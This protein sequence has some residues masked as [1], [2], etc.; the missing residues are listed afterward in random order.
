MKQKVLKIVSIV[1]CLCFVFGTVSVCAETTKPIQITTDNFVEKKSEDT[2]KGELRSKYELGTSELKDAEL[3]KEEIPELVTQEQIK[4]KGHVNRLYDLEDENSVVFQNKDGSET[5]YTFADPVQYKDSK[6]ELKDK[7]RT[8]KEDKS[9]KYAYE[10]TTNDV[11]SYF[12]EEMSTEEGIVV[13]DAQAKITM[14]P[15]YS[16]EKNNELEGY[17]RNSSKKEANKSSAKKISKKKNDN[18]CNGI[19][20]EGMFG[21]G[22]KVRY[23][24]TYTGIKEDIII[25]SP[26]CNNRYSFE[27]DTEDLVAVKEDGYINFLNPLTGEKEAEISPVYI[28]DSAEIP[29]SS[30]E[31]YYEL[32]EKSDGKYIVTL[33]ADEEF[34]NAESTVYPVYLDPSL[35]LSFNV[36]VIKDAIFYKG[37]NTFNET[38]AEG[39]IGRRADSHGRGRMLIS[40][41]KLDTNNATYKAITDESKIKKAELKL[42]MYGQTNASSIRPVLYS[43]DWVNMLENDCSNGMY[44]EWD[45]YT[46]LSDM[47]ATPVGNTSSAKQY[48]FNVTAAVKKWKSQSFYNPK[49]GLMLKVIN[50]YETNTNYRKQVYTANRNSL[51]PSFSITY[52]RSLTLDK[53]NVILNKGNTTTLTATLQPET[54]K[55]DLIFTSSNPSVVSVGGRGDTISGE[56]VKSNV[57]LTG[58]G[59]G[60][61]TIT[62]SSTKNPSWSK[63]CSV[64]VHYNE[65]LFNNLNQLHSLARQ[66]DQTNSIELTLQFIRRQRYFGSNWD[67]VAGNINLDFV[68]FVQQNNSYIYNYFTTNNLYLYDSQYKDIDFIH[69]CA[70]MNGILYGG[71]TYWQAILVGSAHV[72]N[73]AGWA[74]DLQTLVVDVYQNTNDS[75]NYNTF[76][77]EFYRIMGK[78][79]YSFPMSDLLADVDAYNFANNYVAGYW[80]N[81]LMGTA[82]NYYYSDT[83]IP[84]SNYVS[85]SNLRFSQFIGADSKED[86]AAITS[87]YTSQYFTVLELDVKE[88]PIYASE[89]EKRNIVLNLKSNQTQ[90]STDAFVDFI[91]EK[92]EQEPN[93]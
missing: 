36:S 12:P 61:A 56:V 58:V 41:P 21:E 26:E 73:L 9:G 25:D 40:F 76:Y 68:E 32:E 15:L 22:T 79:E 48:T 70:T 18:D 49:K 77:N 34:L 82:L 74:G 83:D 4:E 84:S 55:T 33:V 62:V 28:Y 7:K 85:R 38:T 13:E 72:R 16:Q 86:L 43:Y 67:H 71:G 30:T 53:T 80:G 39:T 93:P 75:N 88:W 20:Y 8:L 23:T 51:K 6:G 57:T 63:S 24:P 69:L 87:E 64:T 5:L 59:Y 89:A 3:S 31:G 44:P 52:N 92:F 37:T 10:V 54:D 35:N 50:D 27:V 19:D 90:A 46:A 47:T 1:L 45:G 78:E 17:A 11:K 81:N 14:K 91:W 66:F 2:G 42:Y 29:N 60:T 65:E